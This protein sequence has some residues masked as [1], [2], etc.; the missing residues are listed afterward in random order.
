MS[1]LAYSEPDQ[2]VQA[3][4]PEWRIFLHMGSLRTGHFWL[5]ATQPG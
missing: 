1:V 2:W 3:L 5:R 4:R